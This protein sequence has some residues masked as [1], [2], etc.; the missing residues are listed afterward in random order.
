MTK[1]NKITFLKAFTENSLPPICNKIMYGK[2]FYDNTNSNPDIDLKKQVLIV[3]DVS[4]YVDIEL[5]DQQ[6][7]IVINKIKTIK[8]HLIELYRFS[9]IAAYLNASFNSKSRSNFRRYESRLKTC[10]NIRYVSYFGNISRQ[11]YDR[12]FI[13]LKNILVKRFTEKQ[14]YNYELQ[15]LEGYRD[16]LFDMIAEKRANLFV[17]YDDN[18]PISIRIN[19]CK[20]KYSL[21]YFKWL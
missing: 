13:V 10:F 1:V 17:I 12:L 9:N 15:H 7:N 21:L 16:V 19:M 20:K 18:K 6:E 14:E 5:H 8:G 4:D 2:Y 3:K 11:E